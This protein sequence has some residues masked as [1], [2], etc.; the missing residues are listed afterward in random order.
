MISGQV[1]A[2]TD[3]VDEMATGSDELD[4]VALSGYSF[5]HQVVDP[6]L[7]EVVQW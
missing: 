7:A 4:R 6:P 1:S 2:K 3:I 5:A